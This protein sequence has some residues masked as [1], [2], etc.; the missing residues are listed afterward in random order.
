MKVRAYPGR[1]TCHLLILMEFL[2]LHHKNKTFQ[3]EIYSNRNKL[4]VDVHKDTD[5]F[6]NFV[7]KKRLNKFIYCYDVRIHILIK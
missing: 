2:R 3:N 6:N 1:Q 5:E 4:F 7:F